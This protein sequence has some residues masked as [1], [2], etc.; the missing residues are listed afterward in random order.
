MN[1]IDES[2]FD[3]IE[4]ICSDCGMFDNDCIC[5]DYDD[6]DCSVCPN[7]KIGILEFSIS[8]DETYSGETVPEAEISKQSCD[9]VLTTE[10]YKAVCEI[11]ER[12]AKDFSF[13]D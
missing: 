2:T 5:G 1:M 12:N 3:D 9:C 6:E 13:Y 10:Q 4:N 11:A 7:C 8:S